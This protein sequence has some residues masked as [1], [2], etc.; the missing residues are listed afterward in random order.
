MTIFVFYWVFKTILSYVKF[1]NFEYYTD[2]TRWLDTCNLV[3][4][5][6][7][8]MKCLPFFFISGLFFYANAPCYSNWYAQINFIRHSILV[9]SFFVRGLSDTGESSLV[10]NN[11]MIAFQCCGVYDYRSVL[12]FFKC[13]T[14]SLT[15]SVKIL[16]ISFYYLVQKLCFWRGFFSSGVSVCLCVCASI[17]SKSYWPILMKFRRMMNHDN[18]LV[19]FGDGINHLTLMM[20]ISHKKKK[21]IK[22]TYLGIFNEIVDRI[23]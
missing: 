22:S 20:R 6:W 3:Y 2:Q 9:F 8:P 15:N 21:R 16:K 19:P 10:L 1:V 12:F 4:G 7:L 17:S 5:I 18:I 23:V 13:L 14:L 11:L